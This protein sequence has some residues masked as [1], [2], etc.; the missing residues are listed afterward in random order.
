M[1]PLACKQHGKGWC[2]LFSGPMHALDCT[3]MFA[4]ASMMQV[5]ACLESV[6][7]VAPGLPRDPV[8]ICKATLVA[9]PGQQQAGLGVQGSSMKSICSVGCKS[10]AILLSISSK[11]FFWG[12]PTMTQS[13]ALPVK[14][15]RR[16]HAGSNVCR[17][18]VHAAARL[19]GQRGGCWRAMYLGPQGAAHQLSD[20]NPAT[21]SKQGEWHA[22]DQQFCQARFTWVFLKAHTKPHPARVRCGRAGADSRCCTRDRPA[23]AL[24][25]RIL[26]A[27]ADFGSK[28]PSA[29]SL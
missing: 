3:L 5:G 10:P 19:G 26:H 27:L 1:A 14:G 16:R 2:L 21:A 13:V 29:P 4:T 20:Q 11:S 18:V 12:N 22:R 7:N 15:A 25:A 23:Q 8:R 24:S 28:V 17:A 6:A 9:V